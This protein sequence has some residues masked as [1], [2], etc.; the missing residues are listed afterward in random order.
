MARVEVAYSA[1]ARQVDLVTVTLP[2]GGDVR[3]AIVASGLLERRGLSLQTLRC[4]VWGRRCEMSRPL[5]E[6]DRVELYRAL[7]V[8][9][10]QARRLRSKG[11]HK[12]KRPAVA[13]R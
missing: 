13:G 8:D 2:A 9:P 6:G 1:A 10:K 7:A 5:C 11:Q 12:A 4:G 3:A